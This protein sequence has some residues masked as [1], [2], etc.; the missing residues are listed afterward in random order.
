MHVVRGSG[1]DRIRGALAALAIAG[2]SAC[3][4]NP[5]ETM[6]NP[7]AQPTPV[8]AP[9]IQAATVSTSTVDQPIERGG[10][11]KI[12]DLYR[13]TIGGVFTVRT[14]QRTGTA[15]AISPTLL[16]TNRHVVE[17]ATR[18]DVTKGGQPV[19]TATVEKVFSGTMD[20]AVLRLAQPIGGVLTLAR[21]APPVGEE[22]LIIG[23]PRG[24]EGSLTR[25]L[26]SQLRTVENIPLLQIDAAVNP[27]NSGSPVFDRTGRV[28]GI[29]FL[30]GDKAMGVAG[31]NFAISAEAIRSAL[32]SDQRLAAETGVARVVAAR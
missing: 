28:I 4:G 9:V 2:L 15:F 18:I 11:L 1:P 13:Q 25:G 21:E 23:S 22:I 31:I 24:L 19:Q 30:G 20:L 32:A 8:E 7:V 26:V 27:G 10:D 3:A 16:L 5:I 14:P 6:T 29:V 17:D 12:S